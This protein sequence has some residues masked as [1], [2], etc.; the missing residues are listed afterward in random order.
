M[1]HQR[2]RDAVVMAIGIAML[3]NTRPYEGMVLTMAALGCLVFWLAK[4]WRASKHSAPADLAPLH[5]LLRRVA[6]PMFLVLGVAGAATAFYCWRVTGS[7]F[8]MPQ[9]VNRETYAVAQY[10]YWQKAFPV[11][12]Y[13][14]K[15]ISDFY[16]RLEIGE[17]IRAQSKIGILE[18]TAHKMAMAWVF[19][20]SPVLT[21][22]LF[23]FP[24][25]LR[26]RRIRPLMIMGA[27]GIAGSALV[28]YFNMHYIAP[29]VPIIIALVMQC[30]RH[31]RLYRLDG[32]PIGALSGSGDRCDEHTC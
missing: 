4:N 26:D 13:H 19:Y 24:W 31:M 27:A 23:W 6:L 3:A 21:L 15:A 1:R 22:P 28:I 11:P 9:Q 2:V 12:Q 10:F 29:L 5:F 14:H 25:A 7:P 32:R 20:F 18:Q 17:F 30:L 8:R 16:T